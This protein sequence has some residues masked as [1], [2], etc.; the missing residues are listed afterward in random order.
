M[1]T[2][3]RNDAVWNKM[4]GECTSAPSALL[5]SLAAL[6]GALH[7]RPQVHNAHEAKSLSRLLLMILAPTV[8]GT[9]SE[10]AH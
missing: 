9:W 5:R 7:N 8:R 10:S 1:G 6:T 2:A 4:V 3:G